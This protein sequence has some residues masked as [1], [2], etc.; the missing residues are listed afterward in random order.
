MYSPQKDYNIEIRPII[1]WI[2]DYD[3]A[4]IQTYPYIYPEIQDITT[5]NIDRLCPP[6]LKAKEQLCNYTTGTIVKCTPTQ[7]KR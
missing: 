4:C 2:T 7:A 5:A 3:C 6:S 1:M